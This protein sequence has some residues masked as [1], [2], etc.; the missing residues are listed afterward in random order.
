[1]S[2]RPCSRRFAFLLLALGLSAVAPAQTG[3]F[4]AERFSFRPAAFNSV[5]PPGYTPDNGLPYDE[6]RGYGWITET[7]ARSAAPVPFNA[8][9]NTRNRRGSPDVSTSLEELRATLIHL[10]CANIC[11]LPHIPTNVAWQRRVPNGTYTV[12][13]GVGDPSRMAFTSGPSR[14]TINVEGVPLIDRFEP[15]VET[16]FRQATGTVTVSDG[17][18]T[19]DAIGGTNTKLNFIE[20]TRVP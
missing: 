11:T 10:Q 1:M 4:P 9:P 2:P 15:T 3:P 7:S 6:A 5:T 13:V 12:T 19:V 18:L 17:L 14:H 20:I 16:P 8:T